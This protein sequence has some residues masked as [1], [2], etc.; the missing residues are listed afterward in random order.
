MFIGRVKKVKVGKYV[1]TYLVIDSS[2]GKKLNPKKVKV[3]VGGMDLVLDVKK[4][5]MG[6]YAVIPPSVSPMVDSELDF[7][8]VE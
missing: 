7:E 3:S 5:R 2:V 4:G 8:V 1:V 6:Y